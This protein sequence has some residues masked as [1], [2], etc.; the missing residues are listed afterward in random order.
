MY[1]IG[2][3]VWVSDVPDEHGGNHKTR[4]V[5]IIQVSGVSYVGVCITK[6]F[7]GWPANVGVIVRGKTHNRTNLPW[8]CAAKCCWFEVFDEERI[9]E[10]SGVVLPKD[11][12]EIGKKVEKFMR[13]G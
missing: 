10:K 8:P 9:K 7:K 12:I 13:Q 4:P 6:S 11:L 3:V 2:D 1:S 5:L